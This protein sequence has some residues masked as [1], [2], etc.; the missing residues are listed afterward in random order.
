MKTE[1]LFPECK[2]NLWGGTKLVEKYGKQTKKAAGKEEIGTNAA[3]LSVFL[4]W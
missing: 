1:K 2:D 3:E 4:C